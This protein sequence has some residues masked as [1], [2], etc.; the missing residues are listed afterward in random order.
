MKVV[1][2]QKAELRSQL[3]ELIKSK[4]YFD[5]VDKNAARIERD[6]EKRR[7]EN[8]DCGII[9]IGDNL[10]LSDMEKVTTVK[11]LKIDFEH[12]REELEL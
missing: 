8:Q 11:V 10:P 4:H 2:D 3:D 12:Q 5:T 7:K 1:N 6:A 9:E